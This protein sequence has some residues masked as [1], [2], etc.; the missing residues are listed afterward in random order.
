MHASVAFFAKATKHE[1]TLHLPRSW[2]Q[3]LGFPLEGCRDRLATPYQVMSCTGLQ[4]FGGLSTTELSQK[5][6]TALGT[7]KLSCTRLLSLF[8]TWF[9]LAAAC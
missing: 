1:L 8:S 7:G 5:T 3:S 9:G 4:S 6:C 2:S